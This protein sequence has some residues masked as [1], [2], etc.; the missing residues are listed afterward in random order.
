[1]RYAGKMGGLDVGRGGNCDRA[2]KELAQ[3]LVAGWI[4]DVYNNNSSDMGWNAWWKNG[5]EWF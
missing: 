1:M 4:V 2:A 5:F 3:K